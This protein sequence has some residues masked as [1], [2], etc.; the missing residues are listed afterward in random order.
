MIG[1]TISHYTVLEELGRGGMG[2]VYLAED[3]KLHRKVALKFLPYEFTRDAEAKERFDHEAQA[4]AVLNHANICTIYEID[5]HEGQS[6]ISMEYIDGRSLKAVIG[7]GPME[8]SAALDIAMQIAGG[9]AEAHEKHVVHRDIKP[10]NIMI[11]GKGQAKIMDFGLAKLRSRTVLTKE[12]TTLGTVAYMSPEQAA[13]RPVDHRTDIWSFGVMFFEMVSGRRPFMGEYDQAMIYSVLNDPPE[14]LT[15]VRTGVPPELERIVTKCMEKDPAERYQTAADLMA[16]LRH[17]GRIMREDVT[18]SRSIVRPPPLT[19]PPHAHP[20]APASPHTPPQEVAPQ[21]PT[22]PRKLRWLPW[23]VVIV[24]VAVLA[25]TLIPRFFG[26]SEEPAEERPASGLKM[27]VVLPFQNLG[28]SDDEYFADG[29]TDAITARLAGLSGLGVISRQSAVQYKDSAKSM[30]TIGEELGVEYIL[31]GT[32]QRERPSDM[33]SR[34]RIIPQLIRCRD[35]IHLWADTYDEDMTEVFR[36]QSEIAERV[37]R[38]LDVTLLEP[39]RRALTSK[40]TENL[41]AYEYYLR[42]MEHADRRVNEEASMECVRMFG[43]AVE[44]DPEFAVAWAQ[45]S[46]S[47]TWLHWRSLNQDSKALADARSA[48]DEAMR[49]DPDLPE[50]HLALGFFYYYG[51]RDYERALERFY[52]VLKQRPGDFETNAAIGFIKRRQGKWDEALRI[53]ERTITMNPRSYMAN[54]DNLGNTY[55]CLGRYDKAENY[56]DRALSLVPNMPSAYIAKAE[57]AILRDGDRESAGSYVQEAIRFTPP[58]RWCY[59]LG[60]LE[61][62]I[63]RTISVS[64]CDRVDRTKMSDCAAMNAYEDA[65]V[66]LTQAQCSIENGR[67]E[68]AAAILDS[69]R[70]VLERAI[71]GAERPSPANHNALA[72]VYAHLGRAEEAIHEAERSV[73]LMPISKD[74][75]DGPAYVQSLAEIYTIVGEY[76]AAIDQLEILFSVPSLISVHALRLDPIWDPLRDNP[77]FQRLLERYSVDPRES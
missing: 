18:T 65:V 12:G 44:L 69:A 5:E 49:I 62:S 16:D 40:P 73:A 59:L 52:T 38:E 3:T 76:E 34:V 20:Q 30:R 1:K 4:A 54:Y 63:I 57:I 36:L 50:A 71:G 64:P 53:F 21:K 68:E 43:K 47:H 35:D 25:I 55:M 51:S 41:E 2:E 22:P 7:E 26:T 31:E 19:T 11:T 42:G 56:V 48:V 33:T 77:R 70:V 8:L 39:E 66:K 13:G 74:A 58:E 15:A 10:A 60:Y 9:L 37:A 61:L 46:I 45:L 28:P 24:L 27:L 72:Y 6:F 17:L 29:I 14:P 67:N 75:F 32:I 23:L